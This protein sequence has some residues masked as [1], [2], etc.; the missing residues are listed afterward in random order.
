MNNKP[1][2]KTF[3]DGTKQ[4]YL[5]DKLHREDGPASEWANGTKIWYINGEL[6]REDG[7]AYENADGMKL[8]Y[9]HGIHYETEEDYWKDIFNLGLITEKELFLKLL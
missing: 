1:I 6:H 4:W 8:W 5:N 3:T 2:C 7:P 9:L